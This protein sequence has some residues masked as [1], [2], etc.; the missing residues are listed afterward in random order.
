MITLPGPRDCRTPTPVRALLPSTG[1]D[2]RVAGPFFAISLIIV[3][4]GAL[5][6]IAP[7]AA[8]TALTSLGLP[9]GVWLVRLIGVG[10]MALGAAAVAEAGAVLAVGVAVAYLSFAVVAETLRRRDDDGGSCGCFG[11]AD[12]PPSVVHAGVNVASAVVAILAVAWPVDDVV[13]VVADQPAG[14]LVFVAF[15]ALVAYLV[16]LLFTALPRLFAP[17]A[18]P[19]ATFRI[20][21]L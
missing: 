19:V 12:T 14:G 11:S 5:K 20:A 9:G 13:S 4:S 8:E 17:P 1:Y 18:K 7:Q 2:L 6:L 15:V 3:L 21:N 10:E 16:F